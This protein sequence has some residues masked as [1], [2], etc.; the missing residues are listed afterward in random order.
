MASAAETDRSTRAVEA[1][2]RG[3]ASERERHAQR[4][5]TGTQQLRLATE[6]VE[7]AGGAIAYA[8][9]ALEALLAALADRDQLGLDLATALDRQADGICLRASGHGSV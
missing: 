1:A 9:D 5:D 4:P 7:P 3:D 8:L 2:Q 6:A